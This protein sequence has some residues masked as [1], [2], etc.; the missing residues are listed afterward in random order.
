MVLMSATTTTSQVVATAEANLSM[1]LERSARICL[2]IASQLVELKDYHAAITLLTPLCTRQLSPSADVFGAFQNRC[3]VCGR[4]AWHH[5]DEYNPLVFCKWEL[6]ARRGSAKGGTRVGSAELHGESHT[7]DSRLTFRHAWCMNNGICHALKVMNNLAVTLLAQ[8][9]VRDVIF[10]L[11]MLFPMQ[12]RC[13]SP[14][15]F[16]GYRTPWTGHASVPCVCVLCGTFH[17]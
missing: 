3:L 4:R 17:L 13:G 11:S 15:I 16:S 6:A 12:H 10:K 9:R 7:S 8:G 5:R 14:R 2:M 1:W